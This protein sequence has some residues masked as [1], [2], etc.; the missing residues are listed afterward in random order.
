MKPNIVESN[1]RVK[2]YGCLREQVPGTMITKLMKGI[3]PVSLCP[4]C[5]EIMHK[6][7]INI[8]TLSNGSLNSVVYRPSNKYFTVRTR[9]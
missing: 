5:T 9:F 6:N 1:K 3:L 8:N 2:C 4:E 7:K